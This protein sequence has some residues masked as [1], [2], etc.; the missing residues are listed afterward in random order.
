MAAGDVIAQ[1]FIEKKNTANY[2]TV[3]TLRFLGF[4]TLLA[5]PVLRT[6]YMTLDFLFK[7]TTKTVALKKVFCDQA[8]FAPS[9]LTVFITTMGWLRGDPW[10]EIQEKVKRDFLPILMAN[11]QLWIPVQ[12]SNFYFVPF[13]HRILVVNVVALFWNTYLAWKSER[14]LTENKPIANKDTQ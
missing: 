8:F 7:G 3:R 5:G 4:G 9:F 12:I 11:Y 2:D 13:H 1:I 10:S 6:W 14:K